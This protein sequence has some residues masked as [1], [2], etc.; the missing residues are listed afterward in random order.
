MQIRFGV[1]LGVILITST[2]WTPAAKAAC[3]YAVSTPGPYMSA[4]GGNILLSILTG[5]SCAWSVTDLPAWLSVSGNGQGTGSALVKL[6]ATNNTGGPRDAVFTLAGVSV[7]VRQ[8][9][10]PACG[11]GFCSIR[12]LP[13]VAFGSEWTTDFFAVNPETHTADWSISFYDDSGSPVALPFTGGLGSLNTLTDTVP[14]QGRKDYE[15]GDATWPVQGAWALV[16]S[17][18]IITT[19][20]IFRRA[21][22]SGPYYEAAVPTGEAYSGFVVPFDTSTFGPTGAPL[23]T[24]FAIAN[25]NPSVPAHVGCTARDDSGAVIPNALTIPTLNPMGHYANY[26]FPALAG[27]R[28]ALECYADTLVSAIALRFIGTDAFSTLPVIVLYPGLD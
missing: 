1:T 3:T 2:A 18:E 6:V 4:S 5:T 8:F 13:H 25:L 22:S 14:A 10:P 23:Y 21:T 28:G 16:T 15:A 20:A 24:G 7:W 9:D 12:P 17:D 26:L 19:E 27:K 11:V